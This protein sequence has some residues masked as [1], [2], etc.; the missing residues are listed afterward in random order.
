[1]LLLISEDIKF[2]MWIDDEYTYNCVRNVGCMSDSA[3]HSSW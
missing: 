1:M 2:V 3:E